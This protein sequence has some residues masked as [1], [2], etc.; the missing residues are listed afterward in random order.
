MH[1]TRYELQMSSDSSGWREEKKG[2][3]GGHVISAMLVELVSER[4]VCMT[5]SACAECFVSLKFNGDNS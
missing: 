1:E 5:M 3:G 2:A 4:V